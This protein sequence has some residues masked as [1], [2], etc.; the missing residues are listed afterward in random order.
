[1]EKEYNDTWD[2]YDEDNYPVD[3]EYEAEYLE[4]Y[5]DADDEYYHGYAPIQGAWYLDEFEDE[6]YDQ[7]R[8]RRMKIH[9]VKAYSEQKQ[10]ERNAVT[11][12][13]KSEAKT[14][15]AQRQSYYHYGKM[16]QVEPIEEEE[17]DW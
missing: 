15:E 1:M 16:E 9:S 12:R 17:E 4:D 2:N 14:R 13:R 5:E 8:G 6:G 10:R 3:E 7:R 11:R